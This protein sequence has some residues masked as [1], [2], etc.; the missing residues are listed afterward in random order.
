MKSCFFL[1]A[2]T[3][4]LA[5]SDL[6]AQA[7]GNIVGTV[8][9]P[10]GASVPGAIVTVINEGTKFSREIATNDSGQF[11]ANSFPTGRITVTVE[12]PG[13]QKLVRSGLS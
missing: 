9:D 13:F 7:L 3:L 12:R 10:G 2:I 11:A 5:A 6:S 8:T 1:C 4:G